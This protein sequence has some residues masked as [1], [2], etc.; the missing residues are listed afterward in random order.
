MTKQQAGR[1]GGIATVKK[2][3]KNHMRSIGKKGA[4]RFHELYQLHPVGQ[5][6]FAVVRRSD[7]TIVSFTNSSTWR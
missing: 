7:N 5:M 3:G 6:D 2:H 4:Q 1:L